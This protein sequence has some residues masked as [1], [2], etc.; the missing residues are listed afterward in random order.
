MRAA[1]SFKTVASVGTETALGIGLDGEKQ[2]QANLTVA[3]ITAS[4]LT[5]SLQQSNDR[6]TW[7]AVG[8]SQVIASIGHASMSTAGVT[9]RYVRMICTPAGPSNGM[10]LLELEL[11]VAGP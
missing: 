9:Q 6:V 11:V 1:M 3:G 5:L 2:V 4:S 7:A 8:L 10:A